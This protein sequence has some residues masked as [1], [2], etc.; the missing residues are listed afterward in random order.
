V[1]ITGIGILSLIAAFGG[2]VSTGGVDPAYPVTGPPS[3]GPPGLRQPMPRS[4]P[5]GSGSVSDFDSP[6]Y[7]MP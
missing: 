3:G 2:C 5:E 7:D 4:T 6:P 1:K